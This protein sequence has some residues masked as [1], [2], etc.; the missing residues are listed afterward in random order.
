VGILRYIEY[1]LMTKEQQDKAYRAVEHRLRE[2]EQI[3]RELHPDFN[4][5]RNVERFIIS[6]LKANEA[7]R[8]L[9][10]GNSDTVYTYWGEDE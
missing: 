3:M 6:C 9:Q 4:S 2:A 10:R 7:L 1:D 5:I 8:Q